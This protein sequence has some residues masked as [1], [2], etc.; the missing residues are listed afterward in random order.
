MQVSENETNSTQKSILVKIWSKAKTL[1]T[2]SSIV[3]LGSLNI[4]SLVSETVHNTMFGGL[5]AVLASVTQEEALLRLLRNSPTVKRKS[6]VATATRILSEER[7]TLSASKKALELKHATLE[8]DNI[9]IKG[10]HAELTRVSAVRSA[11]TQKIS[12]RLATRAVV[13]A[14]RNSSSIFAESIPY[15]GVAVVLGVTVLDLHD[16]CETLKDMNELNATFGLDQEEATKVCGMKVP[17]KA[18]VLSKAKNSWNSTYKAAT[19]A[20]KKEGVSVD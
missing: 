2:V 7:E 5:K 19:V 18:E 13:N 3:G 4:L 10:K 8:K 12:K 9:E 1:L 11:A 16:A 17:T 6:D 15:L 20:L 14:S